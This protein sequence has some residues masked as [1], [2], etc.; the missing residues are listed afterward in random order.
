MK[1]DKGTK[2]LRKIKKATIFVGLIKAIEAKVP[3][4]LPMKIVNFSMD[5]NMVT[6]FFLILRVIVLDV[7]NYGANISD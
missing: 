5:R 2:N 4:P 7:N 6:K 1:K 3:S